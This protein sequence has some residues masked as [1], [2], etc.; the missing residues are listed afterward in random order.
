MHLARQNGADPLVVAFFAFTHDMARINDRIDPQ[1]GPRAAQRI[2]N[3]LQDKFIQI[4]PQQLSWLV[5]AVKLHTYGK[6][7]SSLTV[8]TCW[9]SDRLDLGRAGIYPAQKKLC[10]EAARDRAT[11][12]WAYER[13]LRG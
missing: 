5:E 10:T 3:D 13:S 4:S 2:L 8:M 11:I 9:D 1:H 6:M 7:Q 12:E